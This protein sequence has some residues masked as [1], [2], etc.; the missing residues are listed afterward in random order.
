MSFNS[1][2]EDLSFHNPMDKMVPRNDNKKKGSSRKLVRKF[3][4]MK[5]VYT[6]IKY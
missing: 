2:L 4:P 1:N 5:E 3:L 6:E